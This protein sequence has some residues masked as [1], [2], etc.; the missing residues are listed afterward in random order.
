MTTLTYTGRLVVQTCWCGM[1]HVGGT[2]P[3]GCR[4]HFVDLERHV[5]TKHPDGKLDGEA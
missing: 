3:F 2:C 1:R 4:R 5:T